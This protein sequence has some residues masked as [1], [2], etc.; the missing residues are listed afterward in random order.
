MTLIEIMIVVTIIGILALIAVPSVREARRRAQDTDFVNDVRV[1]SGSVFD[2]SAFEHGD[3]PPDEAPG[4]PPPT[5]TNA[6]PRGFQWSKDAPIGGQWDWDRAPSRGQKVHGLCYAG[7]AVFQPQRTT[8]QLQDI[9][10]RCDDG[11]LNTGLFR[12]YADGCIYII[13]L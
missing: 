9:D 4:V 3:L 12:Q 1:L 6:F 2:Y 10:S 7:L 5:I 8:A 13:E 11:D